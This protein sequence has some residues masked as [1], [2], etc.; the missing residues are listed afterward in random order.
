MQGK[1]S[2]STSNPTVH[3]GS[4]KTHR[5]QVGFIR[6]Y[7]EPDEEC[8]PT[9]DGAVRPGIRAILSEGAATNRKTDNLGQR[10][11][12]FEGRANHYTTKA[13]WGGVGEVRPRDEKRSTVSPRSVG[14]RGTPLENHIMRKGDNRSI[15][16]HA[17]GFRSAQ[18]A[19]VKRWP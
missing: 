18:R 19:A 14:C 4:A 16:R 11:I 2:R 6:A 17:L 5:F 15:L 3:E 1:A 10:L 9:R 13:G 8:E 7:F 12:E